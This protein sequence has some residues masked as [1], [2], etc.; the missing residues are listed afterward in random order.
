MANP[1]RI[2]S[3]GEISRNFSISDETLVAVKERGFNKWCTLPYPDHPEG[4]PNFG[5]REDCPPNAPYFL[6]IYQPNVKIASLAFDFETYLNWRKSFHPDWTERALR[7]VLYY[8]EHLR[9]ELRNNV[10]EELK[11]LPGWEPLY[12]AEAMGVNIHLTCRAV[13]INL[14]WPP[15]IIN[16]RIAILA[17]PREF[18][19]VT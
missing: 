8:Q 14:E 7:N 6:D 17:R 3:I 5:Y 2:N 13:G 18:R 4:C 19:E 10:K 12:N 9:F 16:H 15:K 11:K 1:E